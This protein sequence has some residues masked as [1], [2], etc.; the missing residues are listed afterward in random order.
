MG[1]FERSKRTRD[2][3]Y[4]TKAEQWLR[5]KNNDHIEYTFIYEVILLLSVHVK[6][7][8]SH[9]KYNTVAKSDII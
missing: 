3:R 7:S 5:K 2:S 4:I 9:T 8:V 1:N 6:V